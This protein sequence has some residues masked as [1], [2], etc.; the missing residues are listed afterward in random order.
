MRFT[1]DKKFRYCHFGAFFPQLSFF[2][3]SKIKHQP[4]HY[5]SLTIINLE[6]ILREL[7]GLMD[8]TRAQAFRIYVLLE[9]IM[10]SKDRNFVFATLQVVAPSFKGFNNSQEFL[11][12]S[13]VPTLCRNYLPQE[14]NY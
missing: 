5:L 14:K 6:V 10:V 9:V 13:F 1:N 2:K 11:I 8:L 7:L 4:Q 12:I 3:G